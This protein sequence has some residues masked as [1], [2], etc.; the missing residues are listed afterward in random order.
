MVA[1]SIDQVDV[2]EKSQ[3][4]SIMS[5]IF[6][7]A[8]FVLVWLGEEKD[9]S[10]YA[11]QDPASGIGWKCRQMPCNYVQR[12]IKALFR[13]SYWSR[14]WIIPEFLHAKD[15]LICCGSKCVQLRTVQ[16]WF[17]GQHRF[18]RPDASVKSLIGPAY[19]ILDYRFNWNAYTT[20]SAALWRGDPRR[21]LCIVLQRFVTQEC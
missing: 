6:S 11:M 4:V 15:I 5:R 16:G 1:I 10:D 12:A 9:N 21:M 13:R 19:A 8:A 17:R 20:N 7:S 2:L 14:L 18:R 3:Q